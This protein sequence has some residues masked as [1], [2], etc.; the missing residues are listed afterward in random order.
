MT[1]QLHP[2]IANLNMP[3]FI[4]KLPVDPIR[5]FPVPWF[6]TWVDGRP[7]FRV[8]DGEK[9]HL[10]I[11]QRRCWVCG[12]H[13]DKFA[14]FVLGPMCTINRV[15]AEPP[16]HYECAEYSCLACPF[17]TERQLERREGGEPEGVTQGAGYMIRRNPGCT[18]LWTTTNWKIEKA[19][20]GVLFRVGNPSQVKWFS[21]GRK[22]TRAEVDRSIETGLPILLDLA[23]QESQEAVAAL[24]RMK[25]DAEQWLPAA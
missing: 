3:E 4:R 6:V 20:G 8:A 14:T 15:S 13:L 7:E 11:T 12:Q 25:A 9:L 24:Y 16:C 21:K 1:P 2:S 22:A 23:K 19:T 5:H 17:V 18:A 10:A